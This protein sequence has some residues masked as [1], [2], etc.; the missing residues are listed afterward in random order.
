MTQAQI[1]GKLLDY[2]EGRCTLRDLRAWLASETWDVH[3]AGDSD[4]TGM[5]GRVEL[6]L[7]EYSS[8]HISREEMR[9]EF[10]AVLQPAH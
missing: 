1:C 8:G 7:A 9:E 10:E 2:L 6:A 4:L 3:A 5:V